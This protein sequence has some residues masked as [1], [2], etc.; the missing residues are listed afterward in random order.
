MRDLMSLRVVVHVV[1]IITY[2]NVKSSAAFFV[3]MV[4]DFRHVSELQSTYRLAAAYFL[5]VLQ[6]ITVPDKFDFQ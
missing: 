6:L 2:D 5:E 4:H 3:L 1:V